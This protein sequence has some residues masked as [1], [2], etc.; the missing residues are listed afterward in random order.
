[1]ENIGVAVGIVI[2]TQDEYNDT[3]ISMADDGTGGGIRIPS[4]LISK[5]DG[6]VLMSW[7]KDASHQEY[8]NIIVMAEFQMDNNK[9]NKVDYE[10]WM[11]SSSNRALDFIEDWAAFHDSLVLEGD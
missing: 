3:R 8:E 6:Q 10:L 1:M 7:I 11:T 4:M 2:D 9:E 5:Y